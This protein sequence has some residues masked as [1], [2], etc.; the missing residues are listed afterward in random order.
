MTV[1]KNAKK[2][3]LKALH[4]TLGFIALGRQRCCPSK[5]YSLEPSAQRHKFTSRN[6]TINFWSLNKYQ[7]TLRN[8]TINLCYLDNVFFQFVFV[9]CSALFFLCAV[10]Y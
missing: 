6:I 1:N 5:C 9:F 3:S 7:F 10:K 8:I 4:C 2:R